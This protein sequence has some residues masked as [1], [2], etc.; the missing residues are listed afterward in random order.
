MRTSYF[1]ALLAMLFLYLVALV[2]CGDDDDDDKDG[3]DDVTDDDAAEDCTMSQLCA[4]GVDC[5]GW[6]SVQQCMDVWGE[7]VTECDD[8]EGVMNCNCDCYNEFPDCAPLLDC[9]ADCTLQF[10]I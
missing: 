4:K 9:A 3:E 2:S 7:A 6:T 10:C 1:L 5:G 8:P